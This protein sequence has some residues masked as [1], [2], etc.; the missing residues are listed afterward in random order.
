[1]CSFASQQYNKVH[2]ERGEYF[3]ITNAT[4]ALV[5][6]I[7]WVGCK[8]TFYIARYFVNRDLFDDFYRECAYF[9]WIDDV[10][11]ISLHTENEHICFIRRQ[12]ELM[13]LRNKHERPE[14]LTPEEEI[15]VDHI[16]YDRGE[17]NYATTTP[18]I[19]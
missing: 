8:Q 3:F 10:K 15:L 9:R 2:N 11:D 14:D 4:A 5:R 16:N 7:T 18:T 19:F 17:D 12:S 6:S 13:D 1:M